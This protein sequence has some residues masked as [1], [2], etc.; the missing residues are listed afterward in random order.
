M[1]IGTNKMV[2]KGPLDKAEDKVDDKVDDKKDQVIRS[3]V[4]RPLR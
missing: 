2:D 3:T 4:T 1:G